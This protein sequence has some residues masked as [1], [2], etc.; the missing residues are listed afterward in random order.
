LSPDG[1]RL[2]QLTI[3]AAMGFDSFLV[4]R[5][6]MQAASDTDRLGCYFCN[7]VIAPTDVCCVSRV[8]YIACCSRPPAGLPT[9]TCILLLQSTKDRTLD[10]QCTVTRPGLSFMAAA[11][12]TELCISVLQHPD[13]YV[14]QASCMPGAY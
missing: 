10:Q 7:D 3:N 14:P 4:M 9:C 13:G 1:A 11:L 2:L 6:G 8:M 5:H 12:A